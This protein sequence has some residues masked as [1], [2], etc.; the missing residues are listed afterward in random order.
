MLSDCSHSPP[1]P[2][3]PATSV[4]QRQTGGSPSFFFS[5]GHTTTPLTFLPQTFHDY[6]WPYHSLSVYNWFTNC[7]TA[8]SLPLVKCPQAG[9]YQAS[10]STPET[11]T[12]C[13]ANTSLYIGCLSSPQ[14]MT[15]QTCSQDSSA[16]NYFFS[17]CI[18]ISLRNFNASKFVKFGTVSHLIIACDHLFTL[19]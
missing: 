9:Q 17:V 5:H 13:P 14:V 11:D 15:L 16:G 7:V 18:T 4:S 2:H 8:V 12:V 19:F 3:H 1:L 6:L 10:S